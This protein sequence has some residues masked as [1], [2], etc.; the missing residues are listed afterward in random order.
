[1]E[2]RLSASEVFD[3]IADGTFVEAF[4]CG[5]AAVIS[6]ISGFKSE[7]GEWRPTGQ[8]FATTIR[9]REAV[10][11]LQYGRRPTTTVGCSRS[12]RLEQ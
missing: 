12:S 9:I 2:R 4:C 10:L 11:D 3:G 1:M 5:T 6:P 7:R 8:D